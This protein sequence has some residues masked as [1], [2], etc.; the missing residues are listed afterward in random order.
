MRHEGTRTRQFPTVC[1]EGHDYLVDFGLREFRRAGSLLDRIDFES[2]KGQGMW[3]QLMILTCSR[4][5]FMAVESRHMSD[6]R[7]DGCGGLLLV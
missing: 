5:G 2:E 6:V 1:V 7:C 3:G 4:C